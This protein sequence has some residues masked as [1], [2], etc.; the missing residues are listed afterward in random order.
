MNQRAAAMFIRGRG[1]KITLSTVE[2]RMPSSAFIAIARD[3]EYITG[4]TG[5]VR[6]PINQ[7]Q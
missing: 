7:H 1:Q 5:E 6:G 4:G 3:D 2:P